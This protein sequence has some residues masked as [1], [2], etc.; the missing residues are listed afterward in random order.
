MNEFERKYNFGQLVSLER[1]IS[2]GEARVWWSKVVD[3][4]NL[5]TH[6]YQYLRGLISYEDLLKKHRGLPEG[7]KIYPCRVGINPD[8]WRGGGMDRSVQVEIYIG[9]E[10]DSKLAPSSRDGDGLH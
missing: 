2:V 1:R 3:R 10:I 8:A 4:G 9:S 7:T 6:V 5:Q